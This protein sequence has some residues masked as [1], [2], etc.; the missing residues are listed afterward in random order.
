MQISQQLKYMILSGELEGGTKLPSSRELSQILKVN[1][2]TINNALVTLEGEGLV[3]IQRGI[4]CFVKYRH[5]S[6]TKPFEPIA[7]LAR[8][9]MCKVWSMGYTTED[10]IK[11]IQSAGREQDAPPSFKPGSYMVFI[12]SKRSVL[13]NY[14]RDIEKALN[15]NVVTYMINELENM[16]AET[17]RAISNAELVITTYPHVEDVQELLREAHTPPLGITA[18]PFINMMLQISKW[19]RSAKVAVVMSRIVS[20]REMMQAI[21]DG[22]YAF[23]EVVPC[24][25][26]TPGYEACVQHADHLIISRRSFKWV[27]NLLTPEQKFIIDENTPDVGSIEM[28]KK[29]M[30]RLN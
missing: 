25:L 5:V 26:D 28:L 22:K 2:N 23:Q 27:E 15:I 13:E 29:Y 10:L 11:A 16:D 21:K 9:L 18:G 14:K 8:E 4:G 12:E 24:G 19:P 17:M 1:R 20:T 3:E 6:E 7:E 30:N